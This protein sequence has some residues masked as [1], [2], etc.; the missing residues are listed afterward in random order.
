VIKRIK[1]FLPVLVFTGLSF[2]LFYRYF[3]YGEVPIPGDILLGHYHPWSDLHWGGRGTVYPIKNWSL[4][5]GIRQ[6]FPWRMLAIEEMKKGRWPLWNQYNFSGTPLLGNWQSAAFYPFNLLFWLFSEVDA[7]SVYIILQ[8][9]LSGL[10]MFFFLKSLIKKEPPAFL[11][12]ICWSLSLVM[13]NHMEYGIDGH[14]ALW[15][16]LGLLAIEKARDRFQFRWGSLLSLSVLMTLLAGYPP[17]AVYSLSLMAVYALFKIKPWFS[18]KMALIILFV[19]LALGLSAP[20]TLPAYQLSKRVI[21]DEGIGHE[22]Y[23]L[24]FENLVM[25]FA[26]DFF[27]HFVTRNLFSK[28]FYS[29]APWVGGVGFVFWVL[30]LVFLLTGKVKKNRREI[31]FWGLVFLIPTL[32]MI[33][34]PLGRL[35]RSLPVPFLTAVSP[36]KMVWIS[37]FALAVLAGWGMSLFDGYLRKRGFPFFLVFPVALVL[38]FWFLSFRIPSRPEERLIC[39]RNLVI[40]TFTS[41]T[42]IGLIFFSTRFGRLKKAVGTLLLLL[43]L[44]ELVRQ[45]WKYL[46]FVPKELI[47]PQTE[48]TRFLKGENSHQRL[49]INNGELFPPNVNIAY[50]IPM[51]DGYASIR[52]GRYDY[53][54]RLMDQDVDFNNLSPYSR[55]VYQP[56]WRTQVASLLGGRYVLSIYPIDDPRLNLVLSEGQTRL[57]ENADAF[58]RAFFVERY[59]IEEEIPAIGEKMREIDLR[60]E[61]VLEKD[62]GLSDLGV[63]EAELVDYQSSQV[64]LETSNKKEGMLVLADSYDPGWKAYIDGREAEVFRADLNL[65]SVLVPKGE[66]QVRFEYSPHSFKIGQVVF[67]FSLTVLVV[68]SISFRVRRFSLGDLSPGKR[69]GR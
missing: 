17:P 65:R 24:P 16:P 36:I 25:T 2:F 21:K 41:L 27:G 69:P 33:N 4:F 52:D 55:I 19:L 40:P 54:V 8:P 50:H 32:L 26:P 3:L 61:V 5:D 38:F 57:Y 43:A 53:L 7:W 39:Q 59:W 37:T 67:L 31:I 42:T 60:R 30:A 14:T 18:R 62:P 48:I 11:G 44:A 34:S 29:D 64:V 15:L 13:I 47:F 49:I 46:P 28:S 45:G 1:R 12:G 68:L 23:F 20:Q 56:E 9:F 35:L 6:S 66:H 58:D 10:L 51:I 63:G 22:E